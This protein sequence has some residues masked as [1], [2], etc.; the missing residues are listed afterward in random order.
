MSDTMKKRKL[1]LNRETLLPLQHTD[2]EL[3]AGGGSLDFKKLRDEFVQSG[4][5]SM[6]LS[7]AGSLFASS[8]ASAGVSAAAG[9]SASGAA[10]SIVEASRQLNAP[11]YVATSL[12]SIAYSR[13]Q[14]SRN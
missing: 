3:I 11:C 5:A 10:A 8:A 9:G 4:S 7:G 13:N 2:L 12:A 1:V 14:R 6:L